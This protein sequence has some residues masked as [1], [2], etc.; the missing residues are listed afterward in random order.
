M[1]AAVPAGGRIRAVTAADLPAL[2]DIIAANDLFPPDLLDG[3]LAGHLAGDDGELW[4]ILAD[5]DP[6][7]LAYCA[8]ERM[9]MGTWNLLLIAVHP[10]RQGK[11]AGTSLVRHAEREVAAAGGRLLLVETSGL[12]GFARTRAFYPRCG[13]APEAVIRDF[14]AAGDDKIVFRKTLPPG[15]SEDSAQQMETAR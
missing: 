6:V 3:M 4:C 14:Y 13:F 2:K 9:T 7:A 5:P 11:G 1:T 12:P 15:R 10:E 8:P